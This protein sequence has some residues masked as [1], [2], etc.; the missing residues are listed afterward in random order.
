MRLRKM[1]SGGHCPSLQVPSSTPGHQGA[2]AALAGTPWTKGFKMNSRARL[3]PASPRGPS[4][5]L[6]RAPAAALPSVWESLAPSGRC[7][8]ERGGR[9]VSRAGTRRG[10]RGFQGK[11]AVKAGGPDGDR[12]DAGN[13]PIEA[14]VAGAGG[15][16]YRTS[17]SI[18]TV[19][20]AVEDDGGTGNEGAVRVYHRSGE[21]GLGG[22]GERLRCSSRGGITFRC[23]LGGE[24]DGGLARQQ[25]LVSTGKPGLPSCVN[26]AFEVISGNSIEESTGRYCRFLQRKEHQQPG[27]TLIREALRAAFDLACP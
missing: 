17:V 20:G 12:A 10:E 2:T 23:D 6:S 16:V 7:R 5:A 13:H 26:P 11:E 19:S 18:A 14:K 9:K 27:L 21:E 8:R 15:G 22:R 4:R 24:W 25:F 3:T 1:N